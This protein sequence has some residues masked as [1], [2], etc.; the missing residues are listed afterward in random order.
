MASQSQPM[1]YQSLV[2]VCRDMKSGA[3]TVES[4]VEHQLARIA[5]LE[6]RLSACAM[7]M[8]DSALERA[9]ALDE[10]RLSGAPLGLLHGVPIG[11]KDL[12][13]TKGLETASGTKVMK[14]FVP[15]YDA[16]VVR[17][18][19]DA[20]AVLIAKT[21]LT[22]GAFGSHHPEIRTP[23]NPYSEDHWA[24]VSSSGSGVSVAAG[25]VF[26]ALGTDT[27][28]SIRFPSA[29]CG[30]VG[31]KPTYG[32][33]SR[34]GAFEL[35]GTLDHIGPMTRNVTDAARILSVI[36]GHDA[37][38]STSLADEVPNYEA[39]ALAAGALQ[40]LRIGVD[41]DYVSTGVEADVVATVK[42]AAAIYAE[43]GAEIVELKMPSL[44]YTLAADWSITCAVECARAHAQYYPAQ[45]HLYGPPL[46]Q[47]I[48]MGLS[49]PSSRYDDLQRDRD[50][51]RNELNQILTSVDALLTPCMPTLPQTNAAM[52][53]TVEDENVRADFLLFTAPFDYSGHPTLTLPAG[54]SS[55]GLPQS[56]Q[57]IGRYLEETQLIQLG[58]GY[59]TASGPMPHPE[60]E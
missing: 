43:L 35:A 4:V 55:T 27:G 19:Q 6:P 30:L 21:Q 23:R 49:I 40:G 31:I 51:F 56:F 36:A 44:T 33:V 47:L 37:N 20:G 3:Q 29:S 10:A 34:Y 50:V 15:E 60:F 52:E 8:A 48:E 57:L 17:K 42:A 28:G 25:M 13:Y 38:D 59:E 7:V 18:L 26:G 11:I 9:R 12:L 16:T 32:R 41:W 54:I 46:A 2:D 24:G 22:E 1:H 45:K 14:D 53:T 58:L 39:E 5:D